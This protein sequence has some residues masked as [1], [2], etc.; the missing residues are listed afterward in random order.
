MAY[1]IYVGGLPYATTDEELKEIFASY[2]DVESARVITDRD[3]G[4]SKGFG[5][6]ELASD[7]E[8]EKAV[9]EL[10]GTE[11]GGRRLMVSKARPQEPRPPRDGGSYRDGGGDSRGGYGRGSY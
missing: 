6:V 5:F 11:Y 10:D 7:E 2:G 9:K 4:R 3:S 1:K 8:G